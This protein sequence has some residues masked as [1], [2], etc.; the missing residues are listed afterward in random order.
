MKKNELDIKIKTHLLKFEDMLPDNIKPFYYKHCKT[1]LISVMRDFANDI[2][3][4]KPKMFICS[5][6]GKP[7]D[8]I[9]HDGLC[10]ECFKNDLNKLST[11]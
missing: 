8:N 7:A 11:L 10:A 9:T 5:R 6:C 1:F 4:Q 2:L 3:I